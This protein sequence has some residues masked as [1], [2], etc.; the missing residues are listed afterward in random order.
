MSTME[1]FII[2]IGLGAAA[3][4]SL[5]LLVCMAGKRAQLVKAY[6]MQLEIEARERQAKKE[7]EQAKEENTENKAKK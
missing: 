6:N 7:A 3:F 5:V 4:G 2:V 1:M